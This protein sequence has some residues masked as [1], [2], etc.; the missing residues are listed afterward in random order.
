MNT[1][2]DMEAVLAELGAREPI[3][4]SPGGITRVALYLLTYT[5]I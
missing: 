5:L 3:F 2:A 1:A 4:H